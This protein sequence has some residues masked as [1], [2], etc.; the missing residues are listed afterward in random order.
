VDA[1]FDEGGVA[2]G[3]GIMP[4]RTI[5]PERVLSPRQTSAFERL[6]S[7]LEGGAGAGG[8]S[9]QVHAPISVQGGERAGERVRDGLLTLLN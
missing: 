2:N 7:A 5:Q 4:K 9:I 6:V 3:I 8:K 1:V